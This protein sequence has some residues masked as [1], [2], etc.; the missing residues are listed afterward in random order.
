M[1]SARPQTSTN[2]R[3]IVPV[4]RMLER[5][6]P[7]WVEARAFRLWGRPSRNAGKGHVGG[8]AF[9]LEVSGVTLAAWEWNAGGARGTALLV[10]GWSGNA[11]QMSSFVEPLVGLGFHVVA[12]DLPAHGASPGDFA[13]VLSLGLTVA[14]LATRFRPRVIIAHS[15][16]ATATTYALTKGARP[17]RLVLLA[18]PVQL[19]PYLKHF[20]DQVGLSGAMQARLIKRV[21]AML[22]QPISELD[23]RTHAPTLGDVAALVVHDRADAVV[24]VASSRELVERWPGAQLMETE[25]LSHDRVRREKSV[26][27][28]VV[29]F[30]GDEGTQVSARR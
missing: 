3:F 11:S 5:V 16:G 2:V 12:V 27:A 6:A 23:L 19:P 1:E 22:G 10:H 25:G 14:A 13:T 15:L 24:P 9:R 21:E 7:A 30:V 4:V 8:R 26:V 17:E 29:A 18:P 28:R 20:A